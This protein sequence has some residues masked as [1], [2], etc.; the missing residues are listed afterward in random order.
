MGGRI[1]QSSLNRHDDW[2]TYHMDSKVI[3]DAV[4]EGCGSADWTVNQV[5]QL[6]DTS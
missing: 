1:A 5:G 6:S 4:S 2:G 3:S